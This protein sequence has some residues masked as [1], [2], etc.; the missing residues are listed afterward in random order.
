MSTP[1]LLLHPV[2]L[3]IVQAFL[4]RREL[5]TGQL[6][7]LLPDLSPATLY[8]QVATLVEG[9]VLEVVHE[10]RVRGATERTYRLHEAATAV[11][12]EQAATMT[13]DQHRQ[14]FLTFVAALLADFDRYLTTGDV[15]LGRDRVGFTQRA[16]HLSDEEM[17]AFLADLVAV[18]APRLQH[19]PAPG[20]TR[21]L[22]S[23]VIV[24]DP[25][26]R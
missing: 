22:V 21:R 8:R 12:A 19:E 2:R 17:D 4:G 26:P 9:A 15:D 13:P 25:D 5:T 11:T 10:R 7:T 23:M 1:D 3:R 20:R 18:I 16:M 24:P 6:W 14:G